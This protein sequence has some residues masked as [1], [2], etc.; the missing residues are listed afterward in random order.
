MTNERTPEK[1][2]FFAGKGTLYLGLLKNI[3]VGIA[4]AALVYFLIRISAY[5][6]INNNYLS[7]ENQIKRREGYL[8]ALQDY[9]TSQ[10]LS[11]EDTAQ[12][13]A[14]SREHPYVYLLIYKDDELFF[15]SDDDLDD[16]DGDDKNEDDNTED[17][18]DDEEKEDDKNENQGSGGIDLGDL[19]F[20]SFEEYKQNRDEL[21]AEARANGLYPIELADG[22]LIAALT[23]F[24]Q[25]LYFDVANVAAFALSGL[26][27][28]VVLLVYM[29]KI[30][31]KIKKL[32]FDVTVVS[33][34]DMNHEIVCAGNDELARLSS[35]V[36]TMRISILDKVRSEREAREANTELVTSI[37]HDIRTP[38]TVLL[39]YIDMMKA[40]AE[41]DEVLSG[42][43]A[44]SESTAIRLKRLSD[45]MFKY[46]LTF[47]EIENGITL[48]EY[49]AATLTAQLLDEHVLLLSEN[50][51]EVRITPERG[52][53]FAEGDMI[54]TDAQHLMRIVDNI[55]SNIYKYADKSAPIEM[56]TEREG[57]CVTFKVKN[58][59]LENPDGAE[60][61]GIG[62]KSCARLGAL[63]TNGFAT[64][65]VGDDFIVSVKL[66]LI[67]NQM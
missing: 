14:W 27:L 37:S 38:L 10:G 66:E 5:Q 49:D 55:F 8:E 45:D 17:S 39:G 64:E 62:L 32:E 18:A 7:M 41:G 16:S 52:S 51:Y 13:A 44:A 43:I 24:T 23:E 2:S 31:A 57:D 19:G 20:G 61:N 33:H 28:A 6:F 34:I 26:S 1:K 54:V 42:Y 36:E 3:I 60:S 47:G 50:G 58:R 4:I 25:E 12:L 46:A 59:V 22:T 30:I 48:E 63:I 65:R 21:I 29:S 67:S 40:R 9:A 35:N 53:V 56:T 15:T 11:S